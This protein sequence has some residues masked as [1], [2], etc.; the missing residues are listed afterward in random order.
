MPTSPLSQG[1]MRNKGAKE[2]DA[3]GVLQAGGVISALA[4]LYEHP[5]PRIRGACPIKPRTLSVLPVPRTL[6][7]EVRQLRRLEDKSWVFHR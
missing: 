3:F 6:Q 2:M 7:M 5:C 1:F 4:T